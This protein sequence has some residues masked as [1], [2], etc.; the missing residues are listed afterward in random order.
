[1]NNP[2]SWEQTAPLSS[3]DT[4]NRIAGDPTPKEV[5]PPPSKKDVVETIEKAVSASVFDGARVDLSPQSKLLSML[6]ADKQAEAASLVLE[7]AKDAR[8]NGEPIDARRASMRSDNGN[9]YR[10]SQREPRTEGG[11]T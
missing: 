1:M 8:T 10:R 7:I 3:N 5:A 11:R 4:P 9:K 2:T 6:P